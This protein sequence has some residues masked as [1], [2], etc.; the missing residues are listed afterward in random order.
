MRL[1]ANSMKGDLKAAMQARVKQ[2]KLDLGVS[3]EFVDTLTRKVLIAIRFRSPEKHCRSFSVH[4]RAD[5]EHVHQIQRGMC[6]G[7]GFPQR[8]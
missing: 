7:S 2:Y 4:A 3:K 1:P 6:A 8:S 5:V